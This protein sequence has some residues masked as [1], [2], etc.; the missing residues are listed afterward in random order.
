MSTE[1][2][3]LSSIY[4]QAKQ[5]MPAEH[6]DDAILSAAK[7][8]TTKYSLPY[9]PFSNNWR[10]P[11]SLAAVLVLSVGIVTLM[12]DEF[13]LDGVTPLAVEDTELLQP[14][15]NITEEIATLGKVPKKSPAKP[16]ARSPAKVAQSP[17]DQ[18]ALTFY[19]KEKERNEKLA[20]KKSQASQRAI[21]RVA[22]PMS[23]ASTLPS[24]TSVR[25]TSG[26]DK[27]AMLP[28]WQYKDEGMSIRLIQRLPDQTRSFFIARGFSAEHAELISQ[29][30]VFQ[31]V[32]KNISD[33]GEPSA[34]VYNMDNWRVRHQ[35]RE[36]KMKLR[37][38]WAIQWNELAVTKPAQL[39]FEWSLLPTTQDYQPGDYNW[40]MSIFGLPPAS[41]FA[42]KLTWQQYGEKRS[43]A[44]PD[45][46]CAADISKDPE[47][48]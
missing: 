5:D 29:S 1:D 13:S 3:Q 21:S 33:K 43:V 11:A 25:I 2:K 10:I 48:P 8:E 7:R 34:I 35:G 44:I 30:C 37:E 4:K 20:H 42:L 24:D 18:D 23:L 41:S 17:A 47:T 45:M 9:N 38:K 31:T 40:G 46:Q 22:E 16:T 39:A 27:Q 19:S 36:S 28:Y 14:T 15:E 6:I 12:E 32:F 26:V